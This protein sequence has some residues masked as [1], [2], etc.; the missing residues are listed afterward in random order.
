MI[1]GT[2]P[3]KTLTTY[4]PQ[5]QAATIEP[6]AKISDKSSFLYIGNTSARA[7]ECLSVFHECYDL[8]SF[9]G[10][11]DALCQ[12]RETGITPDFIVVDQSLNEK[13]FANFVLWLHSNKWSYIVPVLY[14]ETALNENELIRLK[15]LSLADDIV[16]IK[17]FCSQLE[18]KAVFIRNSKMEAT[19]ESE[20][21]RE[22]EKKSPERVPTG[23]RIFDIIASSILILLLSPILLMIA[24]IIKF[25]SK[26]PVI[27]KS[28][29]AGRGFK[30]FTFYKFRTMIQNADQVLDEYAGLNVYSKNKKGSQFIK[31]KNDPRVTGFGSFLRNTSLDELPQLFNVLRGDMS[32]VGN[33]PL[34]LYE[35][36]T[37]TTNTSSE[38][39]IAPAGITGLW[40]V[41]KRGRENMN[42]EERIGLDISYA[43]NQSFM[44][45][46]SILAKTP[47]ALFQKSNV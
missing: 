33:R 36:S 20:H 23:K 26:G 25:E 39:F 31:I 35:A 32:I 27:Y 18:S 45:D 21:P 16:N 47:L 29:R 17:E 24:L 11:I 44:L 38:R 37:L 9:D 1:T 8:H 13:E 34:P 19:P 6:L 15:E 41:T 30:I 10:A 22:N 7:I 42:A 12:L 43:R 5:P 28:K 2:V 3:L 14:N 46:C 4:D 40:Q